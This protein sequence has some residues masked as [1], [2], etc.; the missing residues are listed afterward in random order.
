MAKRKAI[1]D[2]TNVRFVRETW[3]TGRNGVGRCSGVGISRTMGND[4]LVFL[5]PLT[6][7]GRPANCQIVI[8]IYDLSGV[9][10]ILRRYNNPDHRWVHNK[11]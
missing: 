6:S 2:S 11:K 9:I 4:P 7:R 5:T 3:F 10:G 1:Y 8:P